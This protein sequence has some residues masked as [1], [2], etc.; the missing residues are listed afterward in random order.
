MPIFRLPPEPVFPDPSLAEKEGVLAVGGDLSPRRLLAAYSEGIFPWYSPGEPILWW[1]PDPRLILEP[2]EL[3]LSHSLKKTL[4]R[5]TYLVTFDCAF[6]LVIRACAAL[7]E[8]GTVGTWITREMERAFTRLH[9]LGV[10][11]SVES[12]SLDEESGA[13]RLAGGLYGLAL[14]GV[15]FGES[16]FSLQPDASKAAFATLVGHL[17]RRGFDL[18]DCQVA[19]AHLL[20]FGAREIPRE[21]FLTRLR[22]SLRKPVP[23]GLWR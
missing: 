9:R 13:P 6:P 7:R 22:H 18:I 1:S 5:Q 4:R 20:R 11:H 3:H 23:A 19:S 8:N 21:L 16:M 15:F 12:W 2:G 17:L 10:A 14:G